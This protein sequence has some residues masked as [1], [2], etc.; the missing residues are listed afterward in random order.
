MSR[1]APFGFSR[2]VFLSHVLTP[3]TPVFPGD[4]PV[5]IS[6]AAVIDRDGYFLQ[7]VA[8]GEQAGTHWAAPAHFSPG[9]AAAD[10]LDPADFFF[11]AAVLDVRAQ[12][13]ADPGYALT[14]RDVEAW[15]AEHGHVQVGAAVLL[16]TGW[17]ERWP[18]PGLEYPGFSADAASW[19]VAERGVAALGT[20]TMGIDPGADRTYAAN[21]VLLRGHR[22]HLEN[23]RALGDLPPAGAWIIVG[24]VR[25]AGGS[26]SPATV[27]GLIP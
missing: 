8:L 14:I 13:T 26:G 23:L 10:Q 24:G 18:D 7:R 27:F 6:A 12:A 3:D 11:P 17:D 9:A 21:R 16:W 2:V 4:P 20:D 25:V 1:G 5:E 15:E 22:I 19:L